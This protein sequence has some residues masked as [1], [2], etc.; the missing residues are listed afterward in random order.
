MGHI[1]AAL[2]DLK[3]Y[4][5]NLN[6]N[7]NKTVNSEDFDLEGAYEN[8]KRSKVPDLSEMMLAVIQSNP[9]LART[10]AAVAVNPMS[11]SK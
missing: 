2:Q 7:D 8:W 9:E 11:Q 10:N 6:L 3:I 4:N 1:L 5:K